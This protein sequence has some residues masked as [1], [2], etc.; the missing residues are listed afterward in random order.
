MRNLLAALILLLG[1]ITAAH[2]AFFSD[3]EARKQIADLKVFAAQLQARLDETAKQAQAADSRLQTLEKNQ[4]V[5]DLL[6]QVEQLKTELSR[7][8]GQIELMTRDIELTQKR[9]RDLYT[10]LD[11]RLRKL[12]GNAPA[13]TTSAPSATVNNAAPVPTPTST[14]AQADVQPSPATQ[15]ATPAASADDMAEVK[16]YEAAHALFKAGKYKEAAEDFDNFLA[17]NPNS[18][19]AAN[20]QYWIGY[21]NFSRKDYKAA[22]AAQQRLLKQYPDHS[23]A[24]DAMYNIANSQIQLGDIDAARQTLSTLIE[25]YPLSDASQLAK[26]RLSAL[27]SVKAK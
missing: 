9:Q 15:S 22:I 6:G 4:A 10:D 8:K 16:A 17:A 18:K 19:Y 26:K 25:K 21:A 11:S 20:A 27:K 7:V 13:S 23:K 5:L 12:E 1:G 3:D 2:A 14:P 24:P